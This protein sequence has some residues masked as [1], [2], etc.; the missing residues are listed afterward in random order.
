[1]TAVLQGPDKY[2][3]EL[4]V[5]PVTSTCSQFDMQDETVFHAG[6]REWLRL[7]RKGV[8]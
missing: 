4:G 3:D 2:A 5:K 1:M 6:Y 8:A 7:M